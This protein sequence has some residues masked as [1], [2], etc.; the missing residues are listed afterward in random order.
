[1]LTL[2]KNTIRDGRLRRATGKTGQEVS[3]P[4]HPDLAEIIAHA[5]AHAAITLAASSLGKP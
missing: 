1:M 2:K 3:L 5:P 4:V